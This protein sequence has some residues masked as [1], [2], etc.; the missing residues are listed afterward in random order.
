MEG[1]RVISKGTARA[2][3]KILETVTHEKGT[4]SSASIPGYRVAGKTGTA[5]VAFGGSYARGK[6][7]SSF[8]GIAPVSNPRLIVAVMVD[9]PSLGSYYASVVAAP[10]FKKVMEEALTTLG[11]DPDNYIIKQEA[12]REILPGPV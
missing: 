2:V 8:V 10:V 7:R 12:K 3:L 5:K 4:G 6:Y 9:E 1:N 11:I